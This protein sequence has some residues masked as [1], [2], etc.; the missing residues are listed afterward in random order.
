MRTVMAAAVLAA[1]VLTGCARDRYSTSYETFVAA[2]QQDAVDRGWIPS[3]LPEEAVDLHEVHAPASDQAVVRASLPSGILP[4]DCVETQ[5]D[6]GEPALDAAWI[7]DDVA[8]R[9]TAVEC[10]IWTGTVEGTTIVLWTDRASEA[11]TE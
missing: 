5:G 4:D 1:L 3:L 10:G 9:G 8:A 7:P 11:D 6:V 2:R